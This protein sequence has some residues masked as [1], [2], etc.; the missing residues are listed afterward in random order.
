ME[1][2]NLNESLANVCDVPP[3]VGDNIQLLIEHDEKS[4]RLEKEIELEFRT[5][6]RHTFPE[7]KRNYMKYLIKKAK[8][9]TEKKIKLI[10]KL[11]A[12]MENNINSLDKQIKDMDE[13]F[14][15]VPK[16]RKEDAPKDVLPAD[17][18]SETPKP[19]THQTLVDD[20]DKTSK[21]N[22]REE[23]KTTKHTELG[24]G[25]KR[26][27]KPK[28]TVRK[29]SKQSLDKLKAA[30]KKKSV[31]DINKFVRRVRQKKNIKTEQSCGGAE[32]VLEPP[33]LQKSDKVQT[34]QN[35][36]GRK[37]TGGGAVSTAPR[38]IDAKSNVTKDKVGR[39]TKKGPQR[40]NKTPKE[41]KCHGQKKPKTDKK[42]RRGGEE[43][44]ISS[45]MLKPS[46]IKDQDDKDEDVTQASDSETFCLC[47]DVAHGNMVACD[48]DTCPIEWF[49]FGCVGLTSPPTDD[50]FCSLCR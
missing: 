9:C 41:S 21:G 37:N 22:K 47:K 8:K 36:K 18:N 48:N 2:K 44:N 31:F 27:N 30:K 42:R 39:S 45:K 33:A 6:K 34:K 50:W 24:K 15:Q 25:K 10:A 16:R 43:D 17:V 7:N 46:P 14:D 19:L 5:L 20:V 4:S 35:K 26:G 1:L 49:H 40:K 23:L 12:F 29:A 28:V 32:N 13:E 3:E 38:R 11:S